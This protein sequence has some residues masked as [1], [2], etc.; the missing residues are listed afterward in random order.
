M[1]TA[2]LLGAH[3]T[4]ASP[5]G[6]YPKQ[7]IIAKAQEIEAEAGATLTLTHDVVAA[8]R[9]ADRCIPTFA[10]AWGLSMR[11]PSGAYFQAVPGQRGFDGPCCRYAVFMHCLPAHRN[12]EVTDTVL[13]GPQS[14]VFEQAE[15]RLHAQKALMVLLLGGGLGGARDL[16][17]INQQ[18]IFEGA[19]MS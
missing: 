2:A 7:E 17:Q 5:K 1:L 11:L 13:D 10:P 18:P 3:C 15:D 19:L 16:R 9:G 8:V 14:V 6:Y 4:V 12:A